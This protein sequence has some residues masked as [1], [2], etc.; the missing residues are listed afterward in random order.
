[1]LIVRVHIKNFVKRNNITIMPKAC[2]MDGFSKREDIKELLKNLQTVIP[3]I[4]ANLYGA[5][6]R[7]E[8]NGFKEFK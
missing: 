7:G 1:M 8:V 6:K 2:P 5:I 4:R 3:H